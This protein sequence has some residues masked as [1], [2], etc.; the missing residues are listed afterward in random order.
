MQNITEAYLVEFLSERKVKPT[1]MRILVLRQLMESDYSLTLRQLE[2]LL[3][4]ADRSTIFRTLSLF[5][6]KHLV[7][8]IDDG[9]G[10]TRYEVCNA[11][12]MS[13]DT[14]QHPHFRCLHCG[15]TICLTHHRMPSI[16]LPDGF[17]RHHANYI[18][19]GLCAKC[20]GEE[21]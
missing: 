1:A 13:E 3:H 19:T 17:V 16:V 4:P 15:Q 6:Q 11:G 12:H 8:T 20:S 14:D 9:S 5:E 18:I 7:H 21:Q 2:E 10:A